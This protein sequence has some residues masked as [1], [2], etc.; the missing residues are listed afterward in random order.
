MEAN[1]KR[2]P[3]ID[4]KAGDVFDDEKNN[5]RYFIDNAGGGETGINVMEVRFYTR[6]DRKMWRR[7]ARGL[8]P[9]CLRVV[10]I[11]PGAIHHGSRRKPSAIE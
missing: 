7:F 8:R 9:L 5:A 6:I 4:P 11:S 1:M 10:P 2:D 3:R